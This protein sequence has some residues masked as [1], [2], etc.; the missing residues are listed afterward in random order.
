MKI[1]GQDVTLQLG[2]SG[3]LYNDF[4]GVG[5]SPLSK[6]LAVKISTKHLFS[7]VVHKKIVIVVLQLIIFICSEEN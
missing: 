2:S 1:I 7:F 5:I 6:I 3:V 4:H